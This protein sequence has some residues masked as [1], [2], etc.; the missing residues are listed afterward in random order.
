M[1]SHGQCHERCRADARA[2]MRSTHNG[3]LLNEGADRFAEKL[4]AAIRASCTKLADDPEML[5]R[6]FFNADA[7]DRYRIR[8]RAARRMCAFCPVRS[9]A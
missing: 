9:D 7:N 5:D 1:R 6:Q 2:V 4:D 8:E 3:F